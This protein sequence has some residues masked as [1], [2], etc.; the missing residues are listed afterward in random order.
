MSRRP[1]EVESSRGCRD[2]NVLP[3]TEEC[4]SLNPDFFVRTKLHDSVADDGAATPS[5]PTF[6]IDCRVSSVLIPKAGGGPTAPCDGEESL[7]IKRPGGQ[8][9]RTC[10]RETDVRCR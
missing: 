2:T 10:R 7:R 6:K 5:T 4:T 9:F 3:G 1:R 8:P